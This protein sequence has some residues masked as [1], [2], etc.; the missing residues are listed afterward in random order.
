MKIGIV[1]VQDSNNFGS[2]LQAYALQ[3]VL[4][5]MGHEVVFIRSRS[6]E[7]IKRI[8]YRVRPNKRELLHFPAFLSENWRGWRKYRCFQSEQKCFRVIDSYHDEP[9]DLVILG[10]DEIWNV[11][12]PVFRTPIFYGA[13]ME[14]VMAYAVSIGNATIEEMECIPEHLFHT[15][16]PIL[17]RDKHTAE[18]LKG[19][20]I[21]APVVCDP[22][23]LVDKTI[24]QRPYQNPLLDGEPF[25]L[26]YS[27]GLDQHISQ[28]IRMFAK[29]HHLRVLSTCFPF[30]WCDGTLNCSPL[31]FCAVLEQA[32]Y[33]F[34]STFHGT[35]F[36]ILN[37]KQ[38]VSL[39]Q[40]RK[41]KDLLNNLGL[42]DHL[43]QEECNKPMLEEKLNCKIIDYGAVDMLIHNQREVSLSLLKA[44]LEKYK[45][46]N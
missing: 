38:F 11:R 40:S 5:D 39:P 35:I 7:Y 22:T 15:I 16:N 8:F 45:R 6:K 41:T 25:L 14:H 17:A 9:F 18:F 37:H 28:S 2:F 30:D 13:G 3:T 1:T 21:I 31:D 26:V 12:T 4:Q 43:I 33:V 42:L 10:S 24:F 29:E 46:R 19:K 36:S 34:T 20:G 32:D 44:G 23:F 27:Y